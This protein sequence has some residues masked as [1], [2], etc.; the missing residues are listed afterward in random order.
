MRS[1]SRFAPETPRPDGNRAKS[2]K[3]HEP[4]LA[5][6]WTS[7]GFS[8]PKGPRAGRQ[9]GGISN[10]FA[11]RIIGQSSCRADGKPSRS[12]RDVSTTCRVSFRH[13]AAQDSIRRN[14]QRLSLPF[15]AE[16]ESPVPPNPPA[17]GRGSD[18]ATRWH[19]V[20]KDPNEGNSAL[21]VGPG[22]RET[23]HWS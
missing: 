8:F 14:R 5:E 13:R 3:S 23:N 22:R 20:K 17:N 15:V 1:L 16:N 21:A 12:M 10:P 2:G 19:R 18:S 6:R 7:N 9:S 4:I 11:L